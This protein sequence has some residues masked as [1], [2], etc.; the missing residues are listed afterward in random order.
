MELLPS[1]GS[2]HI[3]RSLGTP[4]KM[5]LKKKKAP[6]SSNF[7]SWMFLGMNGLFM[8]NVMR[9]VSQQRRKMF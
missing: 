4:V 8:T 3:F 7:K 6:S 9:L 5:V 2:H 1:I